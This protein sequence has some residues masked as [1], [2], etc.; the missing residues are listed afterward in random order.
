M[1]TRTK[2]TVSATTNSVQSVPNEDGRRHRIV[3]PTNT[4]VGAL[5]G[6]FEILGE[7]FGRQGSSHG[8]ARKNET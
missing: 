2:Q 3:T 1:S 8:S 6:G 4:V 7:G 5:K